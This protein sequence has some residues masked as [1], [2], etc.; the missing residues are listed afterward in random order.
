MPLAEYPVGRCPKMCQ[1]THKYVCF[2]GC[3]KCITFFAVS[4][5]HQKDMRG[6]QE[7]H[8]FKPTPPLDPVA[9]LRRW[10]D[11]KSK[12]VMVSRVFPHTM[13]PIL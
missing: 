6:A 7:K 12:L 4:L 2:S 13:T 9:A 10:D 8:C 11:P 5:F 3:G 1:Q